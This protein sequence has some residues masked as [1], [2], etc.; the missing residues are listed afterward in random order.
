MKTILHADDA[1]RWREY[2]R[3]LLGNH[4]RVESV[5]NGEQALAAVENTN[6]DLVILDHLMP[7]SEPLDTGLELCRH[8]RAQRPQ[9]P[10]L[11]FTGAWEDVEADRDALER[12]WQAT[13][14]FKDIRDPRKDN[15]ADRV[16]KLLNA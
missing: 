11:L 6:Y 10:V 15:L 4:Y 1:P 5:G 2:V 14:V 16:A 12:A 9:L 13:I 3:Q 7:G 8:L